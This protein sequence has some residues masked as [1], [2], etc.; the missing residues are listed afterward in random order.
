MIDFVAEARRHAERHWIANSLSSRPLE[1]NRPQPVM[2][3][4]PAGNDN[5][6]TAADRS[7]CPRCN[8]RGDIGCAHQRPCDPIDV[9]GAGLP[10]RS[11]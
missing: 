2:R 7:P 6:P 9:P 11:V 1:I 4:E 10:N 3:H 8:T 5:R